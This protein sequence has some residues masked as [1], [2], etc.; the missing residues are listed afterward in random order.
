MT[1][2]QTNQNQDKRSQA[3]KG[4]TNYLVGKVVLLIGNDTAVLHT[5]VTQLAQ[6]GADI[7]LVCRRLSSETI[8]RIKQSVESL[9]RR[10]LYIVET[11]QKPLAPDYLVR[12]AVS[13]L[14]R[15]DIF[16]DLSAQEKETVTNNNGL[17]ITKFRPT[18]QLR[19]PVLE[20]LAAN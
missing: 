16:I 11:G 13:I 4:P 10:F 3:V 9:G 8:Q 18:W 5:L 2:N 17:T 14:G 19:Q 15:I 6:K 1:N 7:V 12:S 20:Q